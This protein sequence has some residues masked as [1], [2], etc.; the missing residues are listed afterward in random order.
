M[1]GLES[2]GFPLLDIES[3]GIDHA[4]GAADRFGY[5]ILIADIGGLEF[6][7]AVGSGKSGSMWMAGGDP[8]CHSRLNKVPN[9]SVTQKAG[10]S[11]NSNHIRG[12]SSILDKMTS[13][14][15]NGFC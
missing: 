4:S 6:D 7:L 8:Y 15:I 12:H 10:A 5:G 14:L 2:S 13:S 1:D 9:D 11:K 3:D